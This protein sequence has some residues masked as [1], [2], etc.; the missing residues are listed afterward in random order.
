MDLC[1]IY[2]SGL[3]ITITLLLIWFY[4]PLKS[5]IGGL[6]SSDIYLNEHFDTYLLIKNKW[7]G[8]LA[9]CYICCSFWLSLIVGAITSILFGLSFFY[10][11]FTAFTY[12]GLAYLYKSFIDKKN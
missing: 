12:P 2:V 3:L 5:T 6:L 11:M 1:T 9:S 7:L 10:S 8:K 4:S